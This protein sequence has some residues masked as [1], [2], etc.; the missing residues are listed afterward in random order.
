MTR[1]ASLAM[2]C[3]MLSLPA[4]SQQ[5]WAA[6]ADDLIRQL[7]PQAGGPTRGIR[8]LNPTMPE[9]ARE[10]AREA[11]REVSRPVQMH[12]VARAHVAPQAPAATPADPQGTA[13]LTVQFENGS[14]RLTPAA[15]HTL[16]VLGRALSNAALAQYSFRIV[17]H[18]DTVG[19]PE[20]NRTLS[21]RRATTV[22]DYIAAHFGVERSRLEASGRGQEEPLVPTAPGVSEPR[23]RRV[24][25]VTVGS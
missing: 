24:Q 20:S 16:D 14:D 17:G 11:P 12:A 18:T 15:I 2:L 22:S 7:R 8:P 10:P 19:L 21:E 23:N 13:S 5:A 4:W 6:S 3:C 25:V 9:L 1:V